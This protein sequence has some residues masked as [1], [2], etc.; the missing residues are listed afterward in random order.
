M[1]HKVTKHSKTGG[2]SEPIAKPAKPIRSVQTTPELERMIARAA[3]DGISFSFIA[4]NAIGEWLAN[5]GYARKK[6]LAE[7]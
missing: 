3:R 5:R 7:K 2:M 6:D 4:R 1:L